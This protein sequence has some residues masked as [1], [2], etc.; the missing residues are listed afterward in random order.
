MIA[1]PQ[2]W[3]PRALLGT[4]ASPRLRPWLLYLLLSL[5]YTS[6]LFIQP[7][8]GGGHLDWRFFHYLNESSRRIILDYGQFPLWNPW[9][10]GGN[11]HLA[12][13]QTQFLSPYFLLV[14]IFGAPFAAKLFIL[15]H[16]WLGFVGMHRLVQSQGRS[17]ITAVASSLVFGLAGF[18]AMRA[19]GGHATFLPFLYLPWLLLAYESSRE[20]LR[21]SVWIGLLLAETVFEGGI[22]PLALFL[23]VLVFEAVYDLLSE[24]GRWR[25]ARHWR[26][27]GI[28]LIAALV[29]VGVSAVKLGPVMQYLGDAPRHIKLDDSLNLT[30][31]LKAFLSRSLIRHL[32]GHEYV[33]HEYINYIGLLP[34]F[35]WFW[36]W[37]R[38]D[39]EPLR[40]WF[41]ASGLFLLIMIG[42]HGALSPYALLHHL[43][44]F[45]SLRVPARYGV[46]VVFYVAL[47]FGVFINWLDFRAE[48]WARR[49]RH[50]PKRAWL[51]Q[52]LALFALLVVG[53]DMGI[54]NARLWWPGFRIKAPPAK[55][56]DFFQGRGNGN[57]QWW[58]VT[59]N[60]GTPHCYEVNPVPT[61][62]GLWYGPG[63]QMRLQN[64]QLGEIRDIV[65]S[66][67][68]W[69]AEVQLSAPAR[70][71][72]NQNF[73][74]FW[75]LDSSP[76]TLVNA[77][78]QLAVD[79]PAGTQQVVLR[80]WPDHLGVFI[81]LSL[82]SLFASLGAWGI[83]QR[84]QGR[85]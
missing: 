65:F 81:G 9:G 40:R 82:F 51:L 17:P 4:L 83:M 77:Q 22:Y 55:T 58:R 78:G 54:T 66:P 30:L 3:R 47:I 64:P 85:S 52:R 60:E 12:N 24:L 14:L 68:R 10:C 75:Q 53:L 13:A 11:V 46:V 34:V 71:I 20:K 23:L 70:L 27:I 80:Y 76:G 35:A 42:D 72:V 74:R 5:V 37:G 38:R 21:N 79:L 36:L 28:G 44:I 6:P 69:S 25:H 48:D 41:F 26:P 73:Q 15:F 16:F 50:R 2:T 61:A 33:W 63:P 62:K 32:P 45:D 29:F 18:H 84:R 49:F 57:D 31:L 8:G 59:Q 1:L 19:G 56:Q 67:N 7:S 39:E 43:P